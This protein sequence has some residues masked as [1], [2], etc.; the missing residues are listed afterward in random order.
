MLCVVDTN[1]V[2]SGLLNPR[3]KPGA[4]LERIPAGRLV[5]V[6]TGPIFAEYESVLHRKH[7]RIDP[8]LAAGLLADMEYFGV[9]LHPAPTTDVVLPD[10]D[11]TPF[12][13]AA[14]YLRCP[15]V[16]GNRRDFPAGRE[17]EILSPAE[18]ITR[19]P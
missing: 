11:D 15:L 16:T 18:F 8:V 7:L 17:I 6:L 5:P 10:P 1:V 3:G 4:V 13:A 14:K 19:L 9:L 2:V 12:F